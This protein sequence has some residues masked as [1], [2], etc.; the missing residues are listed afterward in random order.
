MSADSSLHPLVGA[1]AGL[2]VVDF[3]QIAAGPLCTMILADLGAEVIKIEPLAGDIGRFLGPPFI[4]E[5]SA[6]FLALNRNKKG[7][8]LD[9]KTPDGLAEAHRLI[10]T[11]DIVVESFRPGVA[12]RLGIGFAKA[13]EIRSG[14][15][16]CSVSAYGQQGPWSSRPGVDGVI[17]AVS[18]LMSIT[19][20]ADEPPSKVQAPIADMATG[21]QAAIAVLAAIQN[22]HRTGE[23]CH[24]DI[25]LFTSALLLQQVPLTGYLVSDEVPLRAGSGAPYAT[26][27]EAYETADGHI[28]IAAYQPSRWQ[29]L[30]D[31]IGAS[32]LAHDTRFYDLAARMDNRG[33]LSDQLNAIF[34][35][36]KTDHWFHLLSEADIICAPICDYS[37]VV[38]LGQ[39]AASGILTTIDHASI[40]PFRTPGFAIGA[41]A[42]ASRLP[43]PR[44]GE[45]NSEILKRSNPG[46]SDAN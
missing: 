36:Q 24:L 42:P 30:C 4:G 37:Q 14:L 23:G 22:R 39:L 15:I 7:I 20:G 26:P 25:S 1:L 46:I 8:T 17:Q 43:P 28:L 45:H 21:Y 29:V 40:G 19:G 10:A 38:E 35:R 12:D 18:G 13:G 5:E 16:Y 31:V 41:S 44:L 2:R 33:A 11:A 32:G 34:R 3:S 27:N 6:V 9:L